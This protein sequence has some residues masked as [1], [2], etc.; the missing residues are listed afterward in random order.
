MRTETLMSRIEV[1]KV[2]ERYC[3]F[4]QNDEQT[5]E[6]SLDEAAFMRLR[7][8]E[9]HAEDHLRNAEGSSPIRLKEAQ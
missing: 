6:F 4:L 9:D 5:I 1:V 2:G 8:A 3:Y 7:L